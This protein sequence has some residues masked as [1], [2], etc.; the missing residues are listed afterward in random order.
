MDERKY[1]IEI[2]FLKIFKSIAEGGW[3]RGPT[4]REEGEEILYR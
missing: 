1:E 4:V 2:D 3:E